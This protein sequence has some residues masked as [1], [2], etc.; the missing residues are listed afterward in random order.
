MDKKNHKAEPG[1]GLR[2][3]KS[4]MLFRA[5]NYELYVRPNK[6]I[7]IFGAIAMFSCIGYMAYM[8]RNSDN[9]KYLAVTS[10]GSI[11]SKKKTSKW[12]M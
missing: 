6:V 8:R 10:D 7:M 5:I 1:D 4:T 12:T 9:T 2:S 11:D 3:L